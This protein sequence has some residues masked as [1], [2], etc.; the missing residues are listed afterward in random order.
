VIV[1]GQG[2]LADIG[3]KTV[4]GNVEFVGYADIEM[5][6]KLMSKARGLILMSQYIEPFGGVQ[7][8][9]LISGT[10]TITSD[11]GAFAENNLHGV[12][13]YRCRTFDHIVWAIRN[14]DRIDPYACRRW[15][16]SN[17]SVERVGEMYEE[18]FQSVMD[19]HTGE[20]WYEI[21]PDRTSLD[22]L[23]RQHP[24][25]GGPR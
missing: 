7:I 5:R 4:P 13:G 20:G 6:K 21:H 3:Y 10:P 8:E 9:S 22:W 16:E 1:A 17:F 18:F 19:I 25:A 15:A 23:F 14:L 12:T 11:W 24:G 2:S